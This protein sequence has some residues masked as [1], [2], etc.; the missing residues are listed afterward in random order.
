MLEDVDLVHV[1][2]RN[3]AI[4]VALLKE[5]V[6]LNDCVWRTQREKARQ[7]EKETW[8]RASEGERERGG[9]FATY[10]FFSPTAAKLDRR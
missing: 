8:E 7:S 10:L 1:E 6:R 4:K 2:K 9:W 3:A 5:L